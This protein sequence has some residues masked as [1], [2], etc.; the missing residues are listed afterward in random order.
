MDDKS[1]SKNYGW[2]ALVVIIG[3]ILLLYYFLFKFPEP[4]NTSEGKKSSYNMAYIA[5][6]DSSSW[7]SGEPYPSYDLIV[8]YTFK[9]N[10]ANDTSFGEVFETRVYQDGI[11]L[12]STYYDVDTYT[13]I[14]NGK[15]INVSEEYKL[16]D[17]TADVEVVIYWLGTDNE[18][19]RKNFRMSK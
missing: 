14:Q 8:N 12:A 16:R 6:I 7:H 18:A 3:I 13:P 17:I 10:S 1:E 4:D 11:Q 15:K 19:D 5:T 2:I 9:N